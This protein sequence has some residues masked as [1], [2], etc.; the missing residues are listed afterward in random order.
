MSMPETRKG[1]RTVKII[2]Q[3]SSGRSSGN[4][5]GT[6]RLLSNG[7]SGR[8]WGRGAAAKEAG[9]GGLITT[10]LEWGIGSRVGTSRSVRFLDT[11]L[12]IHVET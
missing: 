2:G 10:A 11:M 1:T 5:R 3:V 4:R 9:Y 7:S 8:G 12:F 6:L